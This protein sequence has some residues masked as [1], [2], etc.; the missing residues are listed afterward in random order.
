M[1]NNENMSLNEVMGK[2]NVN[3]I[4]LT[5]GGISTDSKDQTVEQQQP[6]ARKARPVVSGPIDFSTMKDADV[7]KIL[8]RRQPK[9][10]Q[11]EEDMM[12]ALDIAVAREKEK[13]SERID[14]VLDA[15]EQEIEEA[16]AAAE[17]DELDA[18]FDEPRA[19][20]SSHFIPSEDDYD[21]DDYFAD[22]IDTTVADNATR[23]TVDTGA[24]NNIEAREVR[25]V[26]TDPPQYETHPAHSLDVENIR[27]VATDEEIAKAENNWYEEAVQPVLKTEITTK[28]TE[29]ENFD[30]IKELGLDDDDE[31]AEVENVSS[32]NSDSDEKAKSEELFE[33]VKAQIKE[34]VD[35]IRKSIDISKFTIS[36]KAVS[37]QKV[38]KMAVKAHQT[39]ADWVLYSVG[40][41]IS[42]SGLSGAEI[43]KM[44]TQVTNRN[45]LNTF[46]D[47]YHIMYDHIIDANKPDFEAWLRKTN[48]V[49]I[50]HIYFALYMATFG[51][52]N[53]MNY[54]CEKCKKVFIQDVK[55]EDMIEY[56]TDDVKLKVANMLRQDSTTSSK[57]EYDVDIVQISN[58]YAFAIKSPSIWS[59]IM[60][61]ASLPDKVLE[62]YSDLID[63]VS[64]IDGVYIINEAT[65]ELVPIDYKVDPNDV[66]KTAARRIKTFY[67]VIS[68]LSSEDYYHLRN[69]I[70]DYDKNSNDISY[71]IPE[72][73]CPECGAKIPANREVTADS[74]VFTRH[75]LAAI[76][77]M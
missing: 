43:L 24:T 77:N 2:P 50:Q 31:E 33:E 16:E 58:T 9:P 72:A 42:A 28:K 13:I 14:A 25:T 52:S 68:S 44:N 66:A 10:S 6:V 27:G 37:A 22:D 36:K 63:I 64:Y 74:L 18:D 3:H 15:Q 73:I 41:P 20:V 5:K 23:I 47:V 62:K 8:P 34:R 46:K 75:Q 7:D 70:A 61:T 12:S 1:S 49:D 32:D 53:F 48:F 35:P 60:E 21:E 19:A 39:V 54:E 71:I 26:M 4:D 59:V 38:M 57:D 45:R 67:D 51:H 55:I 56:A 11:Q 17:E 30:L 76:G 65:S 29:D 40:K 69:I